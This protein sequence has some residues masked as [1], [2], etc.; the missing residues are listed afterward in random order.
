MQK[1]HISFLNL[2]SVILLLL[3]QIVTLNVT[4]MDA[5]FITPVLQDSV[6]TAGGSTP[7]ATMEWE[8]ALV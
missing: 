6:E 3:F 8:N 1:F 7:Q 4:I 5:G 2:C